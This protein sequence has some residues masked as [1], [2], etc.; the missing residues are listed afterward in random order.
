MKRDGFACNS[1]LAEDADST[2]IEK[3]DAFCCRRWVM[4][5]LGV[6]VTLNRAGEVKIELFFQMPMS[7]SIT[8]D[9]MHK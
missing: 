5:V 4:G 7:M 9:A 1:K 2:S 8:A 3:T 6:M